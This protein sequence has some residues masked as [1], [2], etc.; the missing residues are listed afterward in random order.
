MYVFHVILRDIDV[1]PAQPSG[2]SHV[3]L[4]YLSLEQQLSFYVAI[5]KLIDATDVISVLY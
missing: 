3:L 1:A 2:N 4:N 5:V